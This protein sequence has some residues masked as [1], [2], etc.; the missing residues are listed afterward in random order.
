MV[1][2]SFVAA[3]ETEQTGHHR[4][5]P[6]RP[7]RH[8]LLVQGSGLFGKQSILSH[9][10]IHRA[11]G[12]D[13]PIVTTKGGDHDHH[14]DHFSTQCRPGSNRP[15]LPPPFLLRDGQ[16]RT[17][18]Y[19]QVH[20]VGTDINDGYDQRSEKRLRPI[21]RFGFLISPAIK[22]DIVQASLLKIEPTIDAAIAPI[23][24]VPPIASN[25]RHWFPGLR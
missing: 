20:Q 14:G 24:T 18:K 22:G 8:R 5:S 6:E 1:S 4:L 12:Q 9:G 15:R 13:Q 11:P 7:L 21:F 19:I 23:N 2:R 17:R 3:A 25:L 16:F 10:I